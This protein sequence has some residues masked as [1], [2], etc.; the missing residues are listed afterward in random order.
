LSERK[1][2][3]FKKGKVQIKQY[4]MRSYDLVSAKFVFSKRFPSKWVVRK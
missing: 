3:V 1:N 4:R 2:K